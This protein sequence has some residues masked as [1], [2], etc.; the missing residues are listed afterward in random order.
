MDY[1]EAFF[2]LGFRSNDCV[3][4]ASSS[5]SCFWNP[6]FVYDFT[7]SLIDYFKDGT[8][9]MPSFSSDFI[10][11]GCFH[12]ENSESIC[13]KIAE[14]FRTLPSVSRTLYSP[15]HTVCYKGTLSDV[16]KNQHAQ[17][18]YGNTSIFALLKKYNAKIL[19]VDCSFFDG[20]PFINCLE[21]QYQVSYRYWK[22]ISGEIIHRDGHIEQLQ[23]N[24]FAKCID[25]IPPGH[26]PFDEI[27][28]RKRLTELGNEFYLT[29]YVE[30][31]SF[32]KTKF[33]TY[34]IESFY[35]FFEPYLV[36]NKN[37]FIYWTD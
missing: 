17:S 29:N 16:I 37:A 13:G 5:L 9:V 2:R 7:N 33:V 35:E 8:I 15:L 11:N 14:Y 12:E 20:N 18:S 36:E 22:T 25:T 23:T 10:R 34:T 26:I 30:A 3:Y 19:L 21:E 4:V 32:Q 27:A 24:W 1:K 28:R 6:H 31:I